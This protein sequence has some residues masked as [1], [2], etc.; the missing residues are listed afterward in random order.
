M[1]GPVPAE[2]SCELH[3]SVV[4]RRNKTVLLQSR[5]GWME[6]ETTEMTKRIRKFL[7]HRLASR[8]Q[9]RR[10]SPASSSRA[11]IPMPTRPVPSPT[12][13]APGA[14]AKKAPPV[15]RP[16]QTTLAVPAKKV[17]AEEGC[18]STLWSK[19]KMR[20]GGI[21]GELSTDDDDTDMADANAPEVV[22]TPPAAVRCD[23]F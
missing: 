8:H 6:M 16:G 7:R 5:D 1:G 11:N 9:Q 2:D 12:V 23:S 3:Y 21:W 18:E 19:R 14:I 10:S 4:R 20:D 15:F 13:R 22:R 17:A